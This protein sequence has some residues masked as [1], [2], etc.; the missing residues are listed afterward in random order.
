MLVERGNSRPRRQGA[1]EIRR[2]EVPPRKGR[3]GVSWKAS[4]PHADWSKVDSNTRRNAFSIGNR[5]M[6]EVEGKLPLTNSHIRAEQST[7]HG[8]RREKP[9]VW[10]RDRHRHAGRKTVATGAIRDG[11]IVDPGRHG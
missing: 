10:L 8:K 2:S 4:V 11:G 3:T 6:T 1:S 7:T 9:R 5:K